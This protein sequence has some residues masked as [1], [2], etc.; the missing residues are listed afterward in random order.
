MFDKL[1]CDVPQQPTAETKANIET[2]LSS[3]LMDHQQEGVAWM[4]QREKVPD[5]TGETNGQRLIQRW[6]TL[7]MRTRAR[8]YTYTRL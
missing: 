8:I 3:S 4:V 6:K 2:V 7:H 5:P 1:A